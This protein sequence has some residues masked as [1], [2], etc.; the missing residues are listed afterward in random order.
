MA[1]VSIADS[2]PRLARKSTRRW[3]DRTSCGKLL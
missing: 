2:G 3:K 1:A